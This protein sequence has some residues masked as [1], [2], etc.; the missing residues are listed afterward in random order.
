MAAKKS[1]VI[2]P[3]E[4]QYW[5]ICNEY[6]FA[7]CKIIIIKDDKYYFQECYNRGKGV[8]IKEQFLRHW[9]PN[10]FWKL[11]GYK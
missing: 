7:L 8:A 1:T 3:Q 4:G 2:E 10:N 9:K 11:F 5:F 6:T